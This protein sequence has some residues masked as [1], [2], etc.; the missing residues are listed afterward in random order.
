MKTYL[1]KTL[2]WQRKDF[3]N[4]YD[5][6]PLWSSPFGR[7]LLDHV[8]M[9]DYQNYLDI[10]CGTGFPLIELSQR[11]GADCHAYG[12]DPWKEAMLR[13]KSKIDTLGMTNIRL[14]E[15][16]ASLIPF[17]DETFDL[18]TSNLGVNNFDQPQAVL[19]ECFRTLKPGASLCITTNLAGCFDEFFSIFGRT[20]RE[21][22]INNCFPKLE[23]HIRHRGTPESHS[24]HAEKVGFRVVRKVEEEY[25]MRFRNGSAFLNH[26]FILGGFM[27]TWKNIIAEKD[28]ESFF[29]RL[30]SNLNASA[31][32]NGEF[33][34]TIPM[35]YL[36]CRK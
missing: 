8:P 9:G 34:V 22:G 13:A 36:E 6:L 24:G 31:L 1:N 29:D 30:E 11:L 28:R 23:E 15:Q 2:D 17:P 32:Q 33:R 26:S 18:I 35:L 3:V 25:A 27:E 10:G 5:E 12:L 7:L 14:I 4:Q 21:A 16:D 19:A 20:L